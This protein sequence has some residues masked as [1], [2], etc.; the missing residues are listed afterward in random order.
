MEEFQSLQVI[1]GHLHF[2]LGRVAVP[3]K[4]PKNDV[5]AAVDYLSTVVKGLWLACAMKVSFL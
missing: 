5:N 1:M 4:H 3:T 2:K